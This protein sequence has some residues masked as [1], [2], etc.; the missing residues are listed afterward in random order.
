MLTPGLHRNVAER[1]YRDDPAINVSFLKVGVEGSPADMR[2]YRDNPDP[3]NDAMKFGTAVHCFLLEPKRFDST[4]AVMPKYDGR[5]N[6]GKANKAAWIAAHPGITPLEE[7]DYANL[8]GA[9]RS[10]E[11]HAEASKI[12]RAAGDRE[13]V[14]VWKDAK[15]GAMCKARIDFASLRAGLLVDIKTTRDARPGP[16]ERQAAKLHYHMQDAWYR[17]GFDGAEFVFIAVDNAP[18]NGRHRVGVYFLDAEWVAAGARLCDTVLAG[19]IEREEARV[20]PDHCDGSMRLQGPTW[21]LLQDAT[22]RPTKAAPVRSGGYL[23]PS[24]DDHAEYL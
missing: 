5:T 15:T 23:E 6:E 12:I 2:A 10:I 16:W 24:D 13:V 17:R 14:A 22:V 7:D 9:A 18:T 20:W 3:P 8:L 4:Y 1:V 19:W 21:S 11:A